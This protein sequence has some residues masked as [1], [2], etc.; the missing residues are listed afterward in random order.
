MVYQVEFWA[1]KPN[2]RGIRKLQ[3]RDIL[4]SAGDAT[5]ADGTT[6]LD[7]DRCS[8]ADQSQLAA[9]AAQMAAIYNR[10]NLVEP[11]SV[12]TRSPKGS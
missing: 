11:N 6:A 8:I 3:E 10:S 12:S 1:P 4:Y 5:S 2:G 7:D 9:T